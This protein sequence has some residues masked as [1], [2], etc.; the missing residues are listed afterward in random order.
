MSS[1]PPTFRP[2]LLSPRHWPAWIG[3]GLLWLLSCLPY[4]ALMR[5]GRGIGWLIA[6]IPGSRRRIA[7]RNIEL[8]F[9]ELDA[10]TRAR[11]LEDSLRDVGLMLVEFALAWMGSRRA[12]A[13]VPVTIEGIEHIEAARAR[14]QG[15]L[16]TGAHFSHLELAGRLLVERGGIELAGMYREHG[17]AAFEWAIRRA[18]QHYAATMFTKNEV[19]ACVRYMKSGGR[20]WY[21]PDQD[22]RGKDTVFVPFF[23]I[24]ASTLTAT[25]HLA[26][27]SGACVIPFFHRR[28]PEG[29][30]ALRLEA[31]LAGFPGD[32][33]GVDTARINGMIERMTR[34]APNQYL[35]IHRRF[36]TRPK[37]EAPVYD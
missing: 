8:C 35:W 14:G 17:D 13:S 27:L 25:H 31:P 23:G 15:V 34:E 11:L 6:R 1:G 22:M 12:I 32:D 3:L 9:A 18:R 33:V 29:G 2:G 30:Y 5:V 24:S 28:L 10:A 26:R 21:A 7:A 37:G 4:R 20:I 36:K 19:R 16:L